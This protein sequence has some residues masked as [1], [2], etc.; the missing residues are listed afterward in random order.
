MTLDELLAAVQEA[1]P[2]LIDL[3]DR[4]EAEVQ[5]ID[6]RFQEL[7]GKPDGHSIEEVHRQK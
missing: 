3:E 7:P 2:T 5:G 4:L 1:R 6:D